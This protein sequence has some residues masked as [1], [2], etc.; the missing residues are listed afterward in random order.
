[1]SVVMKQ[2]TTCTKTIK[3]HLLFAYFILNRPQMTHSIVFAFVLIFVGLS[4]LCIHSSFFFRHIGLSIK[5]Y[6]KSK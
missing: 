3:L 4:A 1:M 5:P 6:Q 2:A